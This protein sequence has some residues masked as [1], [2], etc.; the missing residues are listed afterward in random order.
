MYHVR[1]EILKL[2]NEYSRYTDEKAVEGRR[3]VR[4]ADDDSIM[5]TSHQI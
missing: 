5:G 1:G 2:K 4:A 3:Q